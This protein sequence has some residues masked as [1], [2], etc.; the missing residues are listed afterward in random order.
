MLLL[1]LLLNHRLHHQNHNTRLS[2]LAAPPR[3]FPLR[4]LLHT[5]LYS[6]NSSRYLASYDHAASLC[7]WPL[8]SSP[9]LLH[10]AARLS[11]ASPLYTHLSWHWPSLRPSHL[12][13]LG[14]F[15]IR[16]LAF[17][18][19]LR[20]ESLAVAAQPGPSLPPSPSLPRSAAAT[21]GSLLAAPPR[22]LLF[23]DPPAVAPF[24]AVVFF[25]VRATGFCGTPKRSKASCPS[26]LPR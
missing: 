14:L 3:Y 11:L 16:L 24:R 9:S 19:A 12:H 1:L 18:V 10:C 22:A 21:G 6:L 15:S 7:P 25:L 5:V 23:P 26:S 4:W 13:L 2:S 17:F 20:L 8:C